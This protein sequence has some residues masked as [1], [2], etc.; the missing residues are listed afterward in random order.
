MLVT[1]SVIITILTAIATVLFYAGIVGQYSGKLQKCAV[2]CLG[3]SFILLSFLLAITFVREMDIYVLRSWYLLPLCWSLLFVSFIIYFA[4]K[5]NVI[6]VF[7]AP[8]SFILFISALIFLHQEKPMENFVTGPLLLV[9]LFLIFSGIALMGIAAGAG[10]LF[11]WQEKLLKNKTKLK[12]MPKNIPSLAA[13]DKVNDIATNIGFPLYTV[14][15][16]S[17]FIWAYM[18]WGKL[19][20]FDYK[21]IISLI[22]LA[23]YGYLFYQRKVHSING[24]KPAYIALCVFAISLFSIFIVN[25]FLPTHHSF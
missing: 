23:L 17:G 18:A 6:F 3:V 11:I 22:I 14:G 25:T 8:L 13:L 5:Q 7:V 2:Y 16:C 12:S 21:E 9:H 15:L 1:L 20:S 4:H 19:F 24:R 10:C